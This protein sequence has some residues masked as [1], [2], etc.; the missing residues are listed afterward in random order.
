[1]DFG[2]AR[3]LFGLSI[4]FLRFYKVCFG[5]CSVFPAGIHIWA[6]LRVEDRIH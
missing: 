4:S 2:V 6:R 5:C 3:L 1:M